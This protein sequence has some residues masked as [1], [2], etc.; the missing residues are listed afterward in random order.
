MLPLLGINWIH[1]FSFYCYI[2]IVCAGNVLKN[3]SGVTTGDNLALNVGATAWH[4]K[5]DSIVDFPSYLNGSYFTQLP[6][7]ISIGTQIKI[8]TTGPA[9][10]Y[11]ITHGGVWGGGY[12][13][14]LEKPWKTKEGYVT[15]SSNVLDNVFLGI[16]LN[17]TTITL[18][19]TTTSSAVMAVVTKRL[20]EGNSDIVFIN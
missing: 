18:P 2:L 12:A 8:S 11:I 15:S 19:R 9:K 6:F 13:E 5:T 7:K 4:D 14:T 3:L 10:V 16:F 17:A 1:N 20:C